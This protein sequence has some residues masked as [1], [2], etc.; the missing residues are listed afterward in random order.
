M[1]LGVL[2]PS[3]GTVEIEGIDIARHRSQALARTN[4]AA[5]Y[6]AL[7]GN[8]TVYQN[9]R[10]FGLLYDVARLNARIDALLAEFDLERLRNTRSGVLSSGEQTRLA[11]AKALLNAPRL[12]LLDE[13]TASLDP[14]AADQ[15]RSRIRAMARQGDC[16]ILWTSQ[17]VRS[18]GDLRPRTVPLARQD[19]A[20]GRSQGIAAR[21]WRRLARGIVH[22]PGARAAGRSTERIVR[23]RPIAAI[24]LRQLYLMRSSPVR[25]LPMIAWVAVDIVLWGFIARYLNSVTATGIN[26]IASLL[27]A[28][29]F[30]D[31]FTRVMQGVTMAF[32]EDVWSRNFINVFASPLLISQYLSGLV[33]TG[34]STSLVGLI[35]M[36][37]IAGAIFGLHFA[38]LGLLLVPFLLV[39]FLFGI[40]LGVLASAMVLRFGPA[41][42]W[43]VWPIPALLSPFV[44]VFYPLAT[45]PSWMRG[46]GHLLPPSYV[47]EALRAFVAGGS[48]SRSALLI[49]IGLA[50]GYVL[51][52]AWVFTAVYRYA[53]RSGLLARYSAES[54]S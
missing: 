3:S 18:R 31:F 22:P 14:S 1:V 4:F 46:I 53:V 42:E 30:W 10:F 41:S 7:P 6:A 27:G 51:L 20:R 15:I 2:Q 45:L 32:F 16:G 24:A 40:A 13:P 23:L 26:F 19:S 39:L 8:L 17:H 48:F 43:L 33:L 37:I 35:V 52:A 47:F 21:T 49:S 29:L 25:V 28:V 12:L 50:A 38:A 44:G 11:L 36:L 34:I 5:V 54:V 9:L